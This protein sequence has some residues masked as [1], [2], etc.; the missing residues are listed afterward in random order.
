VAKILIV[1]DDVDLA[2]LLAYLLE[3]E[4]HQA[5]VAHSAGAAR[6][7]LREH[8]LD[9]VVLDIGLPDANGEELLPHLRQSS[10]AAVLMLSGTNCE[11]T[12]VRALRA[13]ADDY[14][15]K[16]FRPR[17]LLARIEAL[18]RRAGGT[19]AATPAEAEPARL[20]A[21]PI[22]L[23]LRRQE[24]FC[25]GTPLALTPIELRLLRYLMANAGR[26]LT[27]DQI[28]RHVWGYA[29]EGNET[30]LRVH[31]SRLRRKL[32]RWPSARGL[33]ASRPRIGYGFLPSS[34]PPGS[35]S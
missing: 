31:V 16:P 23:D 25:E 30:L 17:L 1:D 7:Q 11:E 24:A 19:G 14:V 34:P 26:V 10:A 15:T 18:L 33:L 4:G 20:D 6:A 13:G 9:L 5:L 27:F 29:G 21:G 22:V 35:A 8:R 32:E 28:I 12:I 2:V 3:K